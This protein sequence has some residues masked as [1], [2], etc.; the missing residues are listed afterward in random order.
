MT[1]VGA[2]HELLYDT[3][4]A[5]RLVDGEVRAMTGDAR[6]VDGAAA[7]VPGAGLAAVAP[8]LDRANAEIQTVLDSLRESRA[9]L[10]AL[11]SATFE[12][13]QHT[14]EKLPDALQV[15]DTTRR[16]L[17]YAAGVLT[18]MQEHLAVVAGLF[19]P[20]ASTPDA[21]RPRAVADWSFPGT[22]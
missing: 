14:S 10:E 7:F 15:R 6:A 12:K 16:Q 4:T 5:L 20:G 8:V 2:R 18:E 19:D 3:E 22:R 9:A 11:A 1:A 17:A 13:P 21:D